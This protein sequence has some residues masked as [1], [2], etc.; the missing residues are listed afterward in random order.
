MIGFAA[1]IVGVFP[2]LLGVTRG[3]CN[4]KCFEQ[5]TARQ[6][7]DDNMRQMTDIGVGGECGRRWT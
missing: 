2:V 4:S 1:E 7:S 3:A 6:R 5:N